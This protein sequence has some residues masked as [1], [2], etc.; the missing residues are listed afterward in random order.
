M[1]DERIG[2]L[3]RACHASPGDLEVARHLVAAYQRAGHEVPYALRL[4]TST[5]FAEL[6]LNDQGMAE[7]R[8]RTT[9]IVFV[10][11][12]AGEFLMGS[13]EDEGSPDE[14]P[15]HRRTFSE[16]F[17]MA[18]YACTAR[19]YHRVTGETP[20]RFP[21]R[22]T[23]KSGLDRL[24]D[25]GKPW[26]D[27]PVET[28]SWDTCQEVVDR[29]N[30]LDFARSSD[31]RFM[32]DGTWVTWADVEYG[33]E[34][35]KLAPFPRREDGEIGV[36]D[37]GVLVFSDDDEVRYQAQLWNE[38]GERTGFQL[39]TEACWEYAA[40]AGSTTQ[41]PNGDSEADLEQIA[42]YGGL[43]ER[44]HKA[45]GLKKPNLWG[46]YD[47]SGNVFEWVRDAWRGTYEG[48]PTNGFLAE[49]EQ[50]PDPAS[51]CPIASDGEA[52]GSGPRL[53]AARPSASGTGRTSGALPWASVLPGEGEQYLED[54]QSPDPM[55]ACP[56]TSPAVV[57]GTTPRPT[58][59]RPAATQTGRALFT[60]TSD[61]VLHGAVE[62]EQRSDPTPARPCASTEAGV[63]SAGRPSAAR[64]TATGACRA[65]GSTT[66]DS[67]SHGEARDPA[68]ASMR[69]YR[70]GCWSFTASNCRS[71]L[72]FWIVPGLR[73]DDL[74]FRF[75]WRA[76]GSRETH[77]P[78][79]EL[80]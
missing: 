15:Q 53:T 32:L 79:G 76:S 44:G 66:S 52:V 70:G 7:Y 63:G 12:P 6:G 77:A 21:T 55:S 13:P 71:A 1:T 23:T 50:R 42:H 68:G 28:V 36:V 19:D 46:L 57:V 62:D 56:I 16:P 25:D 31:V 58:V 14:Q 4:T 74:G 8:H 20:S 11:I 18:K 34:S 27:H 45:V 10:T 61:S 69:V 78:R 65:S 3:E 35:R 60:A 40:R 59:A 37:L 29:T 75:A 24:D 54:E 43:W 17:L 5:L 72:R 38:A 47:T 51:A 49:G 30:R 67:A 33:D 26:G 39:P 41:Y 22:G 9:G 64:P 73:F 2:L 80:R 48:A